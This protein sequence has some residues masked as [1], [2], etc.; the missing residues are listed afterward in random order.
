MSLSSISEVSGAGSFKRGRLLAAALATALLASLLSMFAPIA[1]PASA[2][3]VNPVEVTTGSGPTGM[4]TTPDGTKTYAANI[5]NSTVSVIDNA[6]NAVLASPVVGPSPVAVAVNP[7]GTRAYVSLRGNGLVAVIDTASNTVVPGEYFDTG[8]GVA[9]GIVIS[10][11][12]T[13]AYVASGTV[14]TVRDL[15]AN[16]TSTIPVPGESLWGALTPDGS[17]LYVSVRDFVNG[18]S[19]VVGISTATNMIVSGATTNFGS[20]LLPTGVTVSPDG[21]Y[22][23]V[24][25]RGPGQLARIS[26]LDNSMIIRASGLGQ[27]EQIVVSADSSLIYTTASLGAFTPG[28][29]KVLR[30]SDGG[31]VEEKTVGNDPYGLQVSPDG[32]RVMISNWGGNTVTVFEERVVPVI[33]SACPPAATQGVAYSAQITASGLPLPTFSVTSG[34]LP[35]GLTMSSS[36]LVSGTPTGGTSTFEVTAT[37]VAGTDTLSC[38]LQVSILPTVPG[39]PTG[40]EATAGDAQ[41]SLSWTAPASNGGTGILDYVVEYATDPAGSWTAFTDGVSTGTTAIVTGLTNGTEY[42]FRVSAVNGIGT[43]AASN[44]SAATPAAPVV[45]PGGGGNAGTGG[46]EGET[47]VVVD[48]P[49]LVTTGS[50]GA[51]AIIGLGGLLLVAGAGAVGTT[52]MLR[53]RA[54]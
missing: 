53:R 11:D 5:G 38:D 6:T 44:V 15:V 20:N 34:S 48:P 16:T 2:A 7:A 25:L 51:A 50:Q 49:V 17:M 28:S 14:I 13:R 41:A 36:G 29:I 31:V 39:A 10:A 43:G 21:Q 27:P 45:P 40:L 37:N 54:R 26:T 19:S 23:Y 18:Q 9:H 1:T 8:S 46:G 4:A 22:V 47:S 30:A 12:G 52:L 42:F 3:L 35:A 32:G 24:A 33:I